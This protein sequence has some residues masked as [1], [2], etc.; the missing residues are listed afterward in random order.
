MVDICTLFCFNVFSNRFAWI[1][2]LN[3]QDEGGYENEE[4][5]HA[6]GAH[7]QMPKM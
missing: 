4:A 6:E 3:M 5:E 7:F 1:W 2:D